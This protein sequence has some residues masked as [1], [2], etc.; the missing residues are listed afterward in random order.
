MLVQPV[1]L[2]TLVRLATQETQEIMDSLAQ[3]ELRELL[4]LQVTLEVSATPETLVTQ[5]LTVLADQAA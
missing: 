5:D 1:M 3:V 4:V 2:E